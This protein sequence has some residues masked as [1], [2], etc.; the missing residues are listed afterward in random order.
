[1]KKQW[2]LV[3]ATIFSS[4]LF[5]QDKNN[6]PTTADSSART[7]DEVVVTANKT[8]QKQSSTGKVLTVINR[9]TLQDNAGRS[10]T[11]VLNEQAGL[12]INGSQNAPGTNQ[13]VYLRGAGAA[14][15]LILVDGMPVMDASG[16]TIQFDL[17]HFSIDQVE[18]VE[19]LK[20]AQ[21]TLYGSDAVA[22]VINIITRKSTSTRPLGVNAQ[23]AAGTYG[24]YKGNFGLSGALGKFRYS[25]QYNRLQSKGFSS[26]FDDQNKGGFDKDG[27]KQDLVNLSSSYA[28]NDHWNLRGYY[29]F[30][31]YDAGLDD[32]ALADD[33]NSR[34][35]QRQQLAGLQSTHKLGKSTL[36]LNANYNTV[37][38]VYDDPLN[39]PPQG[40][41][42]W[43]P[44]FGDYK[45][46][47]LFAEAYVS[48]NLHPHLALLAGA[49]YRRNTADIT[50]PWSALGKDSLEAGMM[51]AYASFTLK[52]FDRFGAELGGRF[53]QHQDFGDAVTYAFNPYVYLLPQLK[54]Y[55][56]AAT[57]FRAP[58]LYHLASEYGNTAL[59]PER[60]RQYEA[61]LQFLDN[62][63]T[64]S[65][66]LTFFSRKISDV[67]VFAGLPD[68][69]YGQYR[70]ADRQQDRG[71]E[72]E[73]RFQPIARLQVNAN[74]T[75]LEGAIHTQ[76]AG[77][78][79]S[80]F[81]LYRRP[82]HSFN[83]GTTLRLTDKFNV[84]ISLRWLDKR[85]DTWYNDQTWSTETK[86]L[87]AYY[88]LDAYAQYKI[89]GALELFTDFRNITDRKYFDLYGY[90]TRR[91]NMMA[92]LR[93]GL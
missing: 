66:R 61:G 49:D 64:F 43:D 9:R 3:A 24:T 38:R 12:L 23:L 60:S 11:Q 35:Q 58:S 8:S 28:F 14:N 46:R 29:Q 55:A 22:G 68:P 65:T 83:L 45:A 71:L 36:T 78:D 89:A 44:S 47:A 93:W 90:N 26:A 59:S 67:I 39:T 92:G 76:L 40:P 13:T 32:N 63:N 16:I 80:Y 53:T 52:G 34:S 56:S 21:S 33:P 48:S 4:N 5:A 15:T 70:N 57:A 84:G 51:S 86:E 17:N 81:N 85:Q 31:E 19:I 2:I 72:A 91:F 75:F 82:K 62:A 88:N 73:L 74:Y 20:G 79:T 41:N 77:K 18:R 10:L 42:D 30:S 6:T 37:R 69:P 50:T 25:A 1:M 7:L 27:I 54:L 87:D